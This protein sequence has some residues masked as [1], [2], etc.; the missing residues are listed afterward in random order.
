M[1]KRQEVSRSAMIFTLCLLAGST[2]AMAHQPAAKHAEDAAPPDDVIRLESTLITVPVRVSDRDGRRISGLRLDDFVVTEDS[3][4]QSVVQFSNDQEPI[5]V[6]LLIDASSSAAL[7][8][9]QMQEGGIS[10]VRQLRSQ[11]RALVVSFADEVRVESEPTNDQTALIDAI[12]SLSTGDR[13]QL[14]EAIYLTASQRLKSLNGRKA[15]L[16]FSDGLDTASPTS[17]AETLRY[18]EEAGIFLYAIRFDPVSPYRTTY[19]WSAISCGIPRVN[20]IPNEDYREPPL[21]AKQ[22]QEFLREA[23]EITGGRLFSVKQ[24][25]SERERVTVSSQ[26]A[27]ELR[28]QY[29][30]GYYSSNDRHDGTFRH[31]RVRVRNQQDVAVHARTGYR[32]PRPGG[33]NGPAMARKGK[34]SL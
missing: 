34:D 17:R 13:T 1:K 32:A 5:T 10:F 16:L 15:I 3:V 18:L 19:E 12:R 11:D 27:G 23:T 24:A 8:L 14:Y 26:I 30:L 2:W 25:D 7:H 22:G 28:Q 4:E 20:R 31:L 33:D 6:A 9:R 21:S 29:V